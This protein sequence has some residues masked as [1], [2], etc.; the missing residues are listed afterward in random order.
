[1][2]VSLLPVVSMFVQ[3]Q[4]QCSFQCWFDVGFLSISIW[5]VSALSPKMIPVLV[6]CWFCC[7]LRC[8]SVGSSLELVRCWFGVGFDIGWC[9]GGSVLFD[10]GFDVG[11]DVSFPSISIWL[12][13][14]LVPMILQFDDD[15]SIDFSAG[16]VGSVSVLVSMLASMLTSVLGSVLTSVWL[17]CCLYRGWLRCWFRC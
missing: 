15:P 2:L 4:F 1:M 13:L 14:V 11:F 12:V 8:Q 5:V 7:S 3:Y 10:N 16:W 6:Q 9:N 17:R